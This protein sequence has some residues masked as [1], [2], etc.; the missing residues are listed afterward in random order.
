MAP[1]LVPFGVRGGQRQHNIRDGSAAFYFLGVLFNWP[2]QCTAN[3]QARA[4]PGFLFAGATCTTEVRVQNRY[5]KLVASVFI[6]MKA[7]LS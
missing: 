2:L 6:G 7:V 1:V 5:Y 4:F 3:V